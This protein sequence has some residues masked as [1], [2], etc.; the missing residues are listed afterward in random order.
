MLLENNRPTAGFVA[1]IKTTSSL[2]GSRHEKF[3][4]TKLENT[5]TQPKSFD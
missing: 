4:F 5:Y 1:R 2:G 3:L